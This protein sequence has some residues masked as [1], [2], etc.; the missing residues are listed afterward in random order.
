MNPH[1]TVR[2][3]YKFH[4]FLKAKLEEV[5]QRIIAGMSERSVESQLEF[6]IMIF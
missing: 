6:I 4:V 2:K 1:D 3:Y 5:K